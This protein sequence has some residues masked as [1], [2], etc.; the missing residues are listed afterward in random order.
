MEEQKNLNKT[1]PKDEGG[2]V[3]KSQEQSTIREML[4]EKARNEEEDR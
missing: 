1:D 3:R 4:R 2:D